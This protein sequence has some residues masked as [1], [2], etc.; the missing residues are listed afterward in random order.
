MT[1]GVAVAMGVPVV[2]GMVMGMGLRHEK[3]LY[4]NIT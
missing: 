4:Y 1:V 2:V 3:M